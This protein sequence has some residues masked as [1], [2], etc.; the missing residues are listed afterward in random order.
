[1]SQKRRMNNRINDNP[2]NVNMRLAKKK[3][4]RMNLSYQ[5]V[6]QKMKTL[7]I[8]QPSCETATEIETVMQ[9]I[10][11]YKNKRFALNKRSFVFLFIRVNDNLSVKSRG[12]FF[13]CL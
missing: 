3:R 9:S 5:I 6:H 11:P 8:S 1:M 10:R 13:F 2:S 7:S 4:M 12:C